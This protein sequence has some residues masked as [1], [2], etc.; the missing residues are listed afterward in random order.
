MEFEK[1]KSIVCE[2]LGLDGNDVS[3]TP[4][5]SFT[6]DLGADSLDI[7]QILIGIEDEFD[8]EISDEKMNSIVTLGDAVEAIKEAL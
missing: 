1:L 8:I 7:A 4:E 5:S 3:I 6:D 2:V